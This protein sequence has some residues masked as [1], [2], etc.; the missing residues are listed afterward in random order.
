MPSYLVAL[1]VGNLESRDIGPRSKVCCAHS[2]LVDASFTPA[3]I[4]KVWSEPETVDAGAYEFAETEAFVAAGEALLGPYV[5]G[6]YDLLLLP[7]R[8]AVGTVE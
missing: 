6:V 2:V 4:L 7:P 8:R 1:A 5:W 3:T